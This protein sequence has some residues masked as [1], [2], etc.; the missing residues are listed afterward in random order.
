[1]SML[2]AN[3]SKGE[4]MCSAEVLNQVSVYTALSS[5]CCSEAEE[6]VLARIERFDS[7][8]GLLGPGLIHYP[9]F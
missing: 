8:R 5:V 3:T 6:P 9:L 1:M 4:C 2:Y 7:G